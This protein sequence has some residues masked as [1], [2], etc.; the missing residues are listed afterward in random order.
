MYLNIC[1]SWVRSHSWSRGWRSG[2]W[3][4]SRRSWRRGRRYHWN[5][6][7]LDKR[8][9]L[10]RLSDIPT[11]RNRIW[12]T[13]VSLVPIRLI[14]FLFCASGNLTAW[15]AWLVPMAIEW[16]NN[17]LACHIKEA[18]VG[19]SLPSCIWLEA[20]ISLDPSDAVKEQEKDYD[21]KL[22]LHE[23]RH[24]MSLQF[25]NAIQRWP[26]KVAPL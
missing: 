22:I 20:A 16:A 24:N 12:L 18:L 21:T 14:S 25:I 17:Y 6:W 1:R 10:C 11:A 7:T 2:W 3:G 23:H 5:G 19:V 13:L 4:R 26:V 9:T 15:L 8:K